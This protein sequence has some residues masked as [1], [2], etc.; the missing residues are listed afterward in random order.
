MRI[1]TTVRIF[2]EVLL[3]PCIKYECFREA[4]LATAYGGAAC[5]PRGTHAKGN[6]V[7]DDRD[8][9]LN[10]LYSIRSVSQK[11]RTSGIINER[12]L[13]RVTAAQS[14][15]GRTK[16]MSAGTRNRKSSY[17]ESGE[18]EE[19]GALGFKYVCPRL[20]RRRCSD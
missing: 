14:D 9:G 20:R 17:S 6:N 7:P 19:L 10:Y 15:V 4:T 3:A 5:Q 13:E 8:Y 2:M 11:D 18:K 1:A 16:G 12:Q